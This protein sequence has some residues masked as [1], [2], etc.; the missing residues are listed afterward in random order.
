MCP[1]EEFLGKFS[2]LEGVALIGDVV[3]VKNTASPVSSD[4]HNYGLRHPGAP[5]IPNRC[6]AKIME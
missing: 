6:T 2:S 1:A 3:P 4:L 5:E